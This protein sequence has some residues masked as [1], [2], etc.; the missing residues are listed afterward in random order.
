MKKPMRKTFLVFGKPFIGKEEIV[1][2]VKTLKSGWWGTGPKTERFEHEF[3]AYTGADHALG[4]N[5]ATAGLH[6]ALKALGVGPGDEVITTPLTF[7]STANVILHCGATPVFADVERDTWNIDP[8]EIEKKITKKTKGILPVHLHGSPCDMDAITAIAKRHKLFVVEDAAHASEAI[9]KGKKIG[10]IGDITAFSFYATKNIATGEGGMV[11]TNNKNL[12]EFMRIMSLHGLSR[13]AYKRYSVKYYRHYESVI[14]GFKYNLTD[15]AASIGIHQLA[16]VEAN[17]KVRKKHWESYVQAFTHMPQLILPAP[18]AR[19]TKHARHLFAV[20]LRLE[21]MKIT[22]DEFVDHL[23]KMN[24]GSGVHFN[25]V[26]S[27]SYYRKT[28][29]YRKGMFPNAEFVGER[30]VSLPIGAN[31]KNR[32]IEDVVR[33]VRWI[34]D[35]YRKR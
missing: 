4:V 19:D 29:G 21:A 15:I 31:L 10:S 8:K 2:V 5:S 30:T 13:D 35:S 11:T 14:P 18:D 32:D 27:H 33:A 23:I 34:I 7:V 3:A 1:E 16:R 12:A 9:Y 28:Y 22:R 24:I 17:W 26:P 6:L 25:P 20:L